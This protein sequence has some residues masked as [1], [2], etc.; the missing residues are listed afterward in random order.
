[1]IPLVPAPGIHHA[2]LLGCSPAKCRIVNT[3]A[4][5]HLLR[6]SGD[7]KESHVATGAEETKVSELPAKESENRADGSALCPQGRTWPGS[8][9]AN[10]TASMDIVTQEELEPKTLGF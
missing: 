1:V 5:L 6:G 2:Q 9:S 8:S 4:L 10:T 7:N 3:T